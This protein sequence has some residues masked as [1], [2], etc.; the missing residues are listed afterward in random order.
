LSPICTAKNDVIDG[1]GGHD[2]IRGGAGDDDLTGG[3]GNDS[4]FGEDGDDTLHAFDLLGFDS[5]TAAP[6]RILPT[7]TCSI[8]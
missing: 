2:S 8:C 4:L 5:S 6:A 3:A 7:T 1:N